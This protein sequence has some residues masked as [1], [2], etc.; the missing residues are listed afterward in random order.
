[1]KITL[2][3][4]SLL[5][6]FM[7]AA[8]VI[9]GFSFKSTEA[10]KPGKFTTEISNNGVVILNTET[11][12]FIMANGLE[13]YRQLDWTKGGFDSTFTVARPVKQR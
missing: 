4:R 3:I 10:E 9:L 8:I 1:M 12:D 2:D 5:I 7:A 13:G 11:G 6:G